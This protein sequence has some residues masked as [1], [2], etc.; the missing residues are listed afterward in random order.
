MN[1][2][3]LQVWIKIFS[4]GTIS[5]AHCTCM[6]GLG[7]V[8]SHVAAILFALE[9]GLLTDETSCTGKLALW[10]IPKVIKVEPAKVANM[11]W[12]KN[13]IKKGKT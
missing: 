2:S 13:I 4:S 8:C 9:S 10:K 6:A 1:A 11:N 12:G 5:T 3:N 7:E